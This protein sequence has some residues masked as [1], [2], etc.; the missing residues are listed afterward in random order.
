MRA[1]AAFPGSAEPR[2]V[3]WPEPPGP[4]AGEVLCRTLEL[5]I[6]G[7]DREILQSE[8]P[9]V[10]PGAAYLVLGHECLARV[11]AVGPDVT[12][13]R[14]GDLVT[15]L[16]RRAVAGAA[17]WRSDLLSFGDYTER[18][19]VREHGFSAPRWLDR[20][21]Y[22]LPVPDALSDVAVLTEPLSVAE[23]AV[24]E[25]SLLQS[26]RLGAAWNQT[27][28]RVLVTGLGPIAL[29]AVMACRLRGWPVAV[30]GRDDPDSPRVA[31]LAALLADYCPAARWHR[32]DRPAQADLI[33]ECTGNDQVTLR[34]AE[35]L[36]PRGAMVWLG[37]ERRP[38][39]GRHNVS[40][41]MRNAVLGNHLFLGTVNAARRDV[42]QALRDLATLK[43]TQPEILS[44]LITDRV[45]LADALAHFRDRR[46][47]SI[48][49]VVVYD[50]VGDPRAG[51]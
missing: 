33:L 42:E 5:G 1:V 12:A 49:S 3:E 7:T 34:V 20:P 8:S 32:D 43:Q 22:L 19:I 11:E 21:E 51:G 48:K 40:L 29:A 41:L 10:P 15:P 23:K 17:A 27:P 24:S 13:L 16:V 9:L 30:Y 44:G 39:P 45:P 31:L 2:F 37:S 35:R 36:A 26:A 25:A 18:G 50:H 14:E 28:P 38:R 47:L 4:A 46:P 6:C